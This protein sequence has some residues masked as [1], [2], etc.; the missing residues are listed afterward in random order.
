MRWFFVA[1]G[2]VT[3][4][5]FLS[6]IAWIATR[7]MHMDAANYYV[8]KVMIYDLYGVAV[9]LA[10]SAFVGAWHLWEKLTGRMEAESSSSQG[11][12]GGGS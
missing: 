4:I 5:L 9:I 10:Y 11:G 7:V 6:F 12:D 3:A 2:T 1:F 8:G